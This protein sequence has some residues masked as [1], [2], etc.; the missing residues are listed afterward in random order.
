MNDFPP[1]E[2][3]FQRLEAD[4]PRELGGYQIIARL[5]AGGMGRVYLATTQSG[6]RLAIKVIRP[7]FADDPEFRRRFVHEVAV[8]Q[9]V[10][11]PRIAPLI[12]ADPNGP[13][14]WLATA[15]VPGP[16]LSRVVAE[17]GALPLPAVRAVMAGVA[18][19]LQV[20]H[21]AA[22]VHRDLKP[23]NVLM[24]ADGPCV[25][26]FGIARAADAT[27][28]TRTGV[29]IGS[30]HFM[31]P[32]QALDRPPTPAIDVFALGSLAF[33]A[34]TGRP[35]FGEGPDAAVLFRI[36]REEPDL[37]GC[38]AELRT[39]VSRCLAKDPRSRPE[40]HAIVAELRAP[41]PGPVPAAITSGLAAYETVPTTPLRA[42][43][44][45]GS[46]LLPIAAGAVALSVIVGGVALLRGGGEETPRTTA[47]N[48]QATTPAAAAPSPS[49]ASDTPG[50]STPGPSWPGEPVGA[51]HETGSV[52]MSSSDFEREYDLDALKNGH[53]PLG[54]D[55]GDL[56]WRNTDG[57]GG[58]NTATF[59]LIP[60]TKAPTLADCRSLGEDRWVPAIE[61]VRFERPT[62]FCLRSSEERYGYLRTQSIKYGDDKT[63]VVR[64]VRFYF[65][66]WKKPG[67]R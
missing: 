12:D 23:S 53:F 33:F 44:G 64:N 67:D 37:T 32:E 42:P 61:P 56:A 48:V 39:L 29:R 17:H 20:I 2:P 26:D 6:R 41:D 66:L 35:A 11:G 40:L 4:D 30:P 16:P 49:P 62:S 21:A 1:S 46:L 9:R 51:I 31:S 22:V 34:A 38:P 47:G 57:I 7:E 58:M 52:E 10:L 63:K 65:V 18:E 59:S 43:R 14:P 8:A 28:L 24:T 13:R 15:Y 54:S 27:P 45:P 25:I 50:V 60:G 3:V 36:S 5:G 55:K 19:A